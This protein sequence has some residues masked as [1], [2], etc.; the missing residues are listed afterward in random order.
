MGDNLDGPSYL[1]DEDIE[2]TER[3]FQEK[4]DKLMENQD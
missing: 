3:G 2:N 4:E 1:T